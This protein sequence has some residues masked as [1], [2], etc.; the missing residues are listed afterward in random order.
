MC[1]E[2]RNDDVVVGD[3]DGGLRFGEEGLAF[4]WLVDLD[5]DR[6]PDRFDRDLLWDDDEDEDE[7][8]HLDER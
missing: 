5:G 7:N 2:G 4:F 1:F 3:F 6:L 8:E